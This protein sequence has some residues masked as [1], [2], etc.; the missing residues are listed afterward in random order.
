MAGLDKPF[1]KITDNDLENKTPDEIISSLNG[2]TSKSVNDMINEY[3]FT[4]C[5]WIC[6]CESPIEQLM[7]ISLWDFY[8]SRAAYR[9]EYI[10]RLDIV[11]VRSQSEIDVCGKKYRVD[12]EIPVLDLKTNQ[13][14]I[15]I[16]EC[17]GH[18]F[19]EKTKEQAAKD[20]K[21]DRDLTTAGY[22]VM[23]YTGSEIYSNRNIADEIFQNIKA[24]MLKRRNGR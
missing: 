19:H 9:M 24:I 2:T 16:I 12:F 8:T 22:V 14:T 23:R 5:G 11:E 7:A 4:L 3:K 10:A 21:R 18:E 15:F 6:N 1:R 13:G 20:K 17:D